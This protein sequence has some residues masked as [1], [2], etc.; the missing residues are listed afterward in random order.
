MQK[1]VISACTYKR[2]EGLK[3]LFL[4]L[5][6]LQIP[7]DT[8]V[9]IRIIDNEKTP[10]AKSLVEDLSKQMQC[11]VEYAHE[12]EPGIAPARNRA[13]SEAKNA[14]FLAF[15]DDDETVHP[16]WL[17][18][19][20]KSQKRNNA[21]FV[22]GPVIMSAE[23]K[24]EQ[25]WIDTLLFKLKTFPDDTP[26]HEAWSNNVLIDMDF[27]RKHE[28]QFDPALRFDGGEDTLFFQQ[29]HEK[30]AKGIFASKAIVYEVQ[31]KERLN[32]SWALKRQFRNG[33]TR[34]MI[35]RKTKTVLG[36]S[37]YSAMRAFGCMVFSL[38]HLPTTILKGRIGLA[39]ALTYAARSLGIMWGMLGKKYLEYERAD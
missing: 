14:D 6:G 34:A 15:V 19:L 32:W 2:P 37:V 1:V 24:K 35:A 39:N 3:S 13:L 5:K 36:A 30:G 12:Q 29:M 25:W 38:I 27:I 26:R 16:S 10:E 33:N 28:L 21:H 22:Q 8:D 23:D 11:P 9:T 7:E 17:A 31:P 20:L 4:S 18:E